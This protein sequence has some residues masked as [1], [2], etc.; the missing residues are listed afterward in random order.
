MPPKIGERISVGVADSTET[1]DHIVVGYDTARN[2]ITMP[3]RVAESEATLEQHL[4]SI[5]VKAVRT[6]LARSA[7]LSV[8]VA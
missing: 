3:A 6:G 2:P 7:E 8:A 5:D 1:R 4:G